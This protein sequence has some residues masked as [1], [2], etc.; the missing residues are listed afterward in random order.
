[1]EIATRTQESSRRNPSSSSPINSPRSNGSN[2]NSNININGVQFHHHT[3]TTATATTATINPPISPIPPI[4]RS[5]ET[6]PY[7][8]TFVQADTTN[9]KQV[10]QMLTG[11]SET[12]KHASDPS[13]PPPPPPT[14]T[15]TK[16]SNFVIPPIKTTTPKKQNFKLYERRAN[17][18]KNSL[19]I[20]TLVNNNSNCSNSSSFSPR[21]N[22]PEIL[23]PSLL[24]FPK[25]ALSSPVTPLNI[26]D[27]FNRSSPSLG[28]SSSSSEEERAIAEKG[29]YLHP[30]PISTPRDHEPQLLPL[31]PLTSPRVSGSSS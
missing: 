22:M 2:S 3:T 28:T 11:S 23:S 14:T 5:T 18:F 26:D 19:M 9:F 30:S 15:I 16:S 27:P 6:N 1:M 10:V 7:P 17:N 4:P 12:A 21:N 20:N 29:F 13:P 25:L 8:T 31:F 24:D